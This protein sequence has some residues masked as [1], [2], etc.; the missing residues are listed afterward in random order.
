MSDVERLKSR[1]LRYKK[2]VAEGFNIDDIRSEL[3][4]L[5]NEMDDVRYYA[6]G[7]ED[8]LI[9]ALDG[10]EEE[11]YEFKMLFSELAA[12]AE[13]LDNLIYDYHTD[14]AD[15]FDTF[16]AAVA[17]GAVELLG[18]DDYEDNYYQMTTFEQELGESEAEKRLLRMTKQD[19]ISAARRC[20]GIASAFLNI[21][22]KAEYLRAAMDVLKDK[23]HAFLEAVKGIEE[24]YDAADRDGWGEFSKTVK[25]LDKA[26][27]AL[28]DRVWVE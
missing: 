4:D 10:D 11:A 18:Y 3:R 21:R 12:E 2:S 13:K 5:Q 24:L 25:D 23:N 22:Y 27:N 1:E 16:F 15:L 6:D 7:D 9:E 8:E 14:Y 20:F 28:P 26:L 17:G 19:I